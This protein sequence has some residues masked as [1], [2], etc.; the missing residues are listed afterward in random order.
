MSRL[1]PKYFDYPTIGRVRNDAQVAMA[2]SNPILI[3]RGLIDG[4]TV[5]HK[6]GRNADVANATWEGVLQTAAQFP[7]LTAATTVRVKA[8]GNAADDVSS[9]P[10]GAGA[11]EITVQGLSA[12]GPLEVGAGAGKNRRRGQGGAASADHPAR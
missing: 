8:G 4:A 12:A 10:L 7:W 3:A 11:H 9:S 5:V 2:N 6:F 1:I